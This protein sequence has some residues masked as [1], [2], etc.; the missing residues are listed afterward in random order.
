[1]V[2]VFDRPMIADRACEGFGGKHDRGDIYGC[3][4][5][6]FPKPCR[7]GTDQGF[8]CDTHHGGDKRSP[9]TAVESRSRRKDFDVPVFL[10]ISRKIATVVDLGWG[11]RCHEA[12][13]AAQQAFLIAFNLHDQ[14]IAGLAGDLK[15]FFGSAWRRA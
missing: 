3:L 1:M 11:C 7:G 9:F 15:S 4:R 10:A 2:L 5:A 8:P 12:F 14:V 6:A 13:E